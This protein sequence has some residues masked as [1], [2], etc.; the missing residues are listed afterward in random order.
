M[1][2][3]AME[4]P[5][6]DENEIVFFNLKKQLGVPVDDTSFDNE[7]LLQINAAFSTLQQLGAGPEPFV[8]LDYNNYTTYSWKQY[9][10][11]LRS[12]LGNVQLYMWLRLRLLFDPPASGFTTTSLEK[13][14]DEVTWRLTVQ[15]GQDD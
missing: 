8:L 7:I 6:I 3:P 9:S 15:G 11:D 13:V 10:A 4:Q 12:D 2:I 5:T 1:S 14:L